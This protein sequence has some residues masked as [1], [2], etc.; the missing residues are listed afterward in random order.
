M[1]DVAHPRP[2][3]RRLV[4]QVGGVL[5]H[6][7][8]QC[9]SGHEWSLVSA[10]RLPLLLWLLVLWFSVLEVWAWSLVS[11]ESTWPGVGAVLVGGPKGSE[12][13]RRYGCGAVEAMSAVIPGRWVITIAAV[14]KPAASSHRS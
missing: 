1:V 2:R 6:G 11:R 9:C 12:R 3:P 5:G 13:P 4:G 14:L 7:G 8:L 10:W